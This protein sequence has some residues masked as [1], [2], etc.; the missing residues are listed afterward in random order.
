VALLDGKA[1]IRRTALDFRKELRQSIQIPSKPGGDNSHLTARRQTLN[2]IGL[3]LKRA[4]TRDRRQLIAEWLHL[5][6]RHFPEE[7]QRDVQ[8]LISHPIGLG[9]VALA[10]IA[11][12]A[13]EVRADVFRKENGGE[14]SHR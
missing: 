8:V 10:P 3:K 12:E 6:V 7:L 2:A 14:E 5:R 9:A 13:S 1:Q 4:E 11:A